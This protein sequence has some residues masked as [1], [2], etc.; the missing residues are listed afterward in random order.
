MEY[1][2]ANKMTFI[3]SFHVTGNINNVMLSKMQNVKFYVYHHLYY[4]KTQK[5]I[6][7]NN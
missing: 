7:L 5:F 4:W 2:T 1:L 3:K 6:Y